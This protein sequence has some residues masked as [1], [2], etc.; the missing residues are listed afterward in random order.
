M[1]IKNAV[2][3]KRSL[4]SRSIRTI[5][6]LLLITSALFTSAVSLHQLYKPAVNHYFSESPVS[7]EQILSIQSGHYK[8]ST[9]KDSKHS[10]S[11]VLSRELGAYKS[12]SS[13]G[14]YADF[15]K[16]TS[17]DNFPVVMTYRVEYESGSTEQEF[18]FT[19]LFDRKLI[20]RQ[21]RLLP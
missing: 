10:F 16:L 11:E 3:I 1:V 14:W 17:P 15:S 8:V 21:V 5:C 13:V 20:V 12:H 2:I 4:I 6:F 19:G 9:Q 18:V 7:S